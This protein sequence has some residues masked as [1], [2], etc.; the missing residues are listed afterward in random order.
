MHN[1][2]WG[3]LIP[4][5]APSSNDVKI[6]LDNIIGDNVLLLGCTKSLLP[7]SSIALDQDP[8]YSD[9]KIVI[10]DWLENTIC[11]DTIIGDGCMNILTQDDAN[12]LVSMAKNHSSRLIIRSFISYFPI[13]KVAFNFPT[14]ESFDKKPTVVYKDNFAQFFIWDFDTIE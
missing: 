6:F 8:Y 10:G 1:S 5:L 3:S 11:V 2:Y 12:N 14:I 9:S 7:I 4:P 13:M